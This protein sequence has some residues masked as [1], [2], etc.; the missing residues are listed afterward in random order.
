M[1]CCVECDVESSE[2]TCWMCGGPTFIGTLMSNRLRKR[3]DK[4]EQYQG[5]SRAPY[6]KI[7]T[8]TNKVV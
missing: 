5:S 1:R 4:Y 3:R 8:N 7:K 2:R 6:K